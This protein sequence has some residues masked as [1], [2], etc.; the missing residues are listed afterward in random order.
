MFANFQE[1]LIKIVTKHLGYIF[2]INPAFQEFIII[3]SIQFFILQLENFGWD[4]FLFL[5]L[6]LIFLLVLIHKF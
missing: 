2:R 1:V 3:Y 6:L 4:K 5:N